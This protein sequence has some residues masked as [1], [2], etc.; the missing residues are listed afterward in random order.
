M[1]D[2]IAERAR[3]TGNRTLTSIGDIARH[4][5]IK[6]NDAEIVTPQEMLAE[7]RAEVEVQLEEEGLEELIPYL[8][9]NLFRAAID[10]RASEPLRVKMD[11]MLKIGLPTSVF[12]TPPTATRP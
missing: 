9:T 6:D 2:A 7:L 1:T 8:D 4:Q 12:I 10:Q 3:K 5:T 11:R